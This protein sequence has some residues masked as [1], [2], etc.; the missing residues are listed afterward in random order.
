M[1]RKDYSVFQ[2]LTEM[3]ATLIS[4]L[5]NQKIKRIIHMSQAVHPQLTHRKSKCPIQSFCMKSQ[6]RFQTTESSVWLLDQRTSY[7]SLE[8]NTSQQ[9]LELNLRKTF[10]PIETDF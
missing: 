3:K 1:H 2:P 10:N 7:V 5:M 4:D 6:K 8:P 9:K